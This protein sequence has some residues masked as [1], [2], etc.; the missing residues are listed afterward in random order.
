MS[1]FVDIPVTKDPEWI[2]RE[3]EKNL[4][5]AIG[6]DLYDFLDWMEDGDFDYYSWWVSA[7]VKP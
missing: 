1:I 2:A 6:N 4:R 5:A 7:T 3:N